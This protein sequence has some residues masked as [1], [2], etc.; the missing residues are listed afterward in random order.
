MFGQIESFVWLIKIAA[1][2]GG[3]IVGFLLSGP[4]LR[5]LYRLAFQRPVPAWLVPV[6]KFAGAAAC[7]AL[8]FILVSLG[9]GWGFGLGPGDGGKG[10]GYA[11]GDSGK[12]KDKRKTP[13]GSGPKIGRT[14]LEIELVGGANFKGEGRFYLVERRPPAKTLEEVETLIREQ[15]GNL[16]VHLV[17]TDESV[18]E[19]NPPVGLL[20]DVLQRHGVPFVKRTEEK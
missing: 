16:E 13:D 5:L 7:A 6:G 3:A 20:C 9:G 14:K 4:A 8:F 17:F 10:G 11:N 2:L 1:A 19:K 15:A 18:G 12:T